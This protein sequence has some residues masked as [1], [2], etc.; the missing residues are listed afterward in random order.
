MRGGVVDR[1][2]RFDRHPLD[3]APA[4]TSSW[5]ASGCTHPRRWARTPVC[6][7]ARNRSAWPHRDFDTLLALRP[8]CVVYVAS[9][10]EQDAAAVPDY[11]R[12]LDAGVN[13]VTVSSWSAALPTRSGR[14]TWRDQLTQAAEPQASLYA[15]GIEPGLRR[16]STPAGAHDAVEHD[17]VDPV[18]RA[19]H[20]RRHLPGGVHDD[21]RHGV[22]RAEWSFFFFCPGRRP[23]PGDRPSTW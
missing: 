18:V 15:S 14:P 4:R 10:P 12:F 5:S 19:R 8:D 23:A 11:V 2:D 17:H 16:R 1:V 6:S 22:R 21:G 20:V 9:G 13:V 7:R 3:P